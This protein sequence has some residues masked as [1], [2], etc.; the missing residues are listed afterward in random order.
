MLAK[1]LIVQ[2]TRLTRDRGCLRHDDRI[3]ALSMAVAYWSAAM[4][5]NAE[6]GAKAFQR[7]QVL[8]MANDDYSKLPGVTSTGENLSWGGP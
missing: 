8:E 6:A 5:Q 7:D 2:M 1:S 3:D 4:A